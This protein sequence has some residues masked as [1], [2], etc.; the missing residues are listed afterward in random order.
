VGEVTPLIGEGDLHAYVDGAL[1]VGLR[2]A[3]ELYLAQNPEAAGRVA[4]YQAQR[5]ALR[6]AVRDPR[7]GAAAAGTIACAHH[8]AAKPSPPARHSDRRVYSVRRVASAG[9]S[10]LSHICMADE[11]VPDSRG[12]S[13]WADPLPSQTGAVSLAVPPDY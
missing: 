9:W 7:C 4:A 1:E 8:H 13:A 11:D 3:V 10:P 6:K 2:P 5:E 12:A